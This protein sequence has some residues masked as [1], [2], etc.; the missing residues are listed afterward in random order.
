MIVLTVAK[1][2][3]EGVF[4]ELGFIWVMGDVISGF[5]FCAI[6]P[7]IWISISVYSFFSL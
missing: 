2:V 4:G 1:V 3:L 6:M 5:F 7:S